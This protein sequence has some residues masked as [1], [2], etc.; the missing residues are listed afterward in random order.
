VAPDVDYSKAV[1]LLHPAATRRTDERLGG[2]SRGKSK[3]I[4]KLGTV[5]CA[6]LQSPKDGKCRC[7]GSWPV[8][9]GLCARSFA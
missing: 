2:G 5:A 7:G 8:T 1:Q 9:A 3:A 6:H 4:I